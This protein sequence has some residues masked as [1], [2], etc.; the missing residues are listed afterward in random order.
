MPCDIAGKRR[1]EKQDSACDLLRQTQAP[2]RNRIGKLSPS[3][4][5]DSGQDRRVDRT[6][7]DCVDADRSARTF[8][9]EDAYQSL[10]TG[11]GG[12]VVRLTM[13]P[14]FGRQ[15]ANI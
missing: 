8:A 3:G 2:E 9:G 13:E 14:H 12:R 1:A 7:S 10:D 5:G 15:A 11:L 6:G 4:F